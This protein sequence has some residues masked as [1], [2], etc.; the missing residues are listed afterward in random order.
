[1]SGVKVGRLEAHE[2][3][4]TEGIRITKTGEGTREEVGIKC[5]K[6]RFFDRS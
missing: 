1:M 2:R 3:G 6:S 4:V 5:K